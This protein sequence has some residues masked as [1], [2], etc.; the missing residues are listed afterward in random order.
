MVVLLISYDLIGFFVHC[1]RVYVGLQRSPDPCWLLNT[2]TRTTFLG[3]V[4]HQVFSERG[5]RRRLG[6]PGFIPSY[7][8]VAVL[9]REFMCAFM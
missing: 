9:S 7:I 6:R 2:S 4:S 1:D 5:R 8:W 3:N